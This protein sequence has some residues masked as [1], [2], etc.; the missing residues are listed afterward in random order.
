MTEGKALLIKTNFL[1]YKLNSTQGVLKIKFLNERDLLKRYQ[2]P[3]VG[4]SKK[5]AV[6]FR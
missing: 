5:P 4:H 1:W 6:P 3:L 2:D